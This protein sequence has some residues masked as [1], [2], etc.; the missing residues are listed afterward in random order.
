MKTTRLRNGRSEVLNPARAAEFSPEH[1][2]P[3]KNPPIQ[4]VS[5]SVSL[6]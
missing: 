6:G 4:R 3:L 1:A 5:G 2:H